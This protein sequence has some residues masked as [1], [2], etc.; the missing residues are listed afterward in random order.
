MDNDGPSRILRGL[1]W[2][3]D[4]GA[5]GTAVAS[6]QRRDPL[7]VIKQV[8]FNTEFTADLDILGH[9][10]PPHKG[11]VYLLDHEPQ[12]LSVQR[13]GRFLLEFCDAGDL[14]KLAETEAHTR[15]LPE[16]FIW[17]VF[18]RLAES[19]AF[20]HTGWSAQR[21]TISKPW[22]TV[23][24]HD[25][26]PDNI[27]LKNRRANYPDIII[28]D[29]GHARVPSADDYQPGHAYGTPEFDPPERPYSTE[30]GDIWGLGAIIHCLIHN[31]R[32]FSGPI[33]ENPW[34]P[35]N[36]GAPLPGNAPVGRYNGDW[37]REFAVY[38][39]ESRYL[40]QPRTDAGHFYSKRLYF[41]AARCL[42]YDPFDRPS[43]VELCREMVPQARAWRDEHYEGL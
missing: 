16:A 2:N 37:S 18:L 26:K 40:Q 35:R 15:Y 12:D 29:F 21:Q 20:M 1:I 25:L 7:V 34:R 4:L 3:H 27:F 5:G 17:H 13:P 28:G 10:L 42:A 22:T 43:A 41:W 6:L 38:Y 33:C 31:G 32:G 19:I 23:L 24:H 14:L 8:A 30:K 39:P 11:I 36:G 9:V